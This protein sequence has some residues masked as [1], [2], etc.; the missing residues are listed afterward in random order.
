MGHKPAKAGAGALA[1]EER[2]NGS[3]DDAEPRD[4]NTF[5]LTIHVSELFVMRSRSTQYLARSC[6]GASLA[7]DDVSQE[8]VDVTESVD[9]VEVG[10]VK[11]CKTSPKRRLGNPPTRLGALLPRKPRC[12]ASKRHYF[13][14]NP[15]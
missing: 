5:R 14:L 6:D 1:E 2:C 11:R 9:A 3:R 7:Q 4:K 8:E 15:R 10:E 13:V 12:L